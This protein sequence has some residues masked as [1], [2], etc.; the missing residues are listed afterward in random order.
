MGS[1]TDVSVHEH[2]DAT[3]TS[4]GVNTDEN[5]WSSP[6]STLPAD[7]INAYFNDGIAANLG[8]FVWFDETVNPGGAP[9]T[10]LAATFI[11]TEAITVRLEVQTPSRGDLA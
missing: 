10:R 7:Q 6:T 2:F 11:F 5:T 9:L 8:G 1:Y 3:L 4:L